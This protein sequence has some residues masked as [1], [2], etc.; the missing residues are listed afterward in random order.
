MSQV[1]THNDWL[2]GQSQRDKTCIFQSSFLDQSSINQSSNPGVK[3]Q[4]SRHQMSI[5]DTHRRG[6]SSSSSAQRAGHYPVECRPQSETWD[7]I[8]RQ[9]MTL[10]WHDQGAFINKGYRWRGSETKYRWSRDKAEEEEETKGDNIEDLGTAT[11]L[12]TRTS[13]ENNKTRGE[14]EQ[15]GG[16]GRRDSNP[17]S[18]D[19]KLRGIASWTSSR[20]DRLTAKQV[21]Q[22]HNKIQQR[23]TTGVER[24]SFPSTQVHLIININYNSTSAL[25]S[26]SKSESIWWWD[27][28]GLTE[29]IDI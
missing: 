21:D 9:K 6:S 5:S 1:S 15:N 14:I 24:G 11:E 25:E 4:S 23:T 27:F 22:H 2:E 12:D 16:G 20:L 17:W 8:R 29:K 7:N 3:S 28:G 10:K 13:R 18:R 19:I 26:T